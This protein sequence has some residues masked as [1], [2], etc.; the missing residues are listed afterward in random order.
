MPL[1]RSPASAEDGDTTVMG[2]SSE[3]T[4]RD[5]GGQLRRRSVFLFFLFLF[6]RC[7][8]DGKK[9]KLFFARHDGSLGGIA[10]KAPPSTDAPTKKKTKTNSKP[11]KKETS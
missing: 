10:G 6:G 5:P 8:R 4:L 11:T 1:D 3:R 2:R 9:K 7:R